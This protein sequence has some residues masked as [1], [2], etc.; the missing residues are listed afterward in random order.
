MR[1]NSCERFTLLM[2]L[3]VPA[4]DQVQECPDTKQLLSQTI[5]ANID[6]P[7]NVCYVC[8][9]AQPAFGWKKCIF[10]NFS[11]M[12]LLLDQFKVV[13]RFLTS[14]LIM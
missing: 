3:K 14:T 13:K 7:R 6:G 11:N 4:C 1:A 9:V 10:W 2:L 5:L 12:W 8:Y